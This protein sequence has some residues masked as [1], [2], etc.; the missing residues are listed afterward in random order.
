M[1]L[2]IA[3]IPWDDNGLNNRMFFGKDERD[4]CNVPFLRMKQEFERRGDSFDTI[5]LY[6][7][8]EEVDYF[9]FFEFD[10]NW[11]EKVVKAGG[12]KRMIYCNAEPPVVNPINSPQGYQTIFK[13]FPYVLTW[14]HEWID[15]KRI[16]RRNIPYCFNEDFGN[17]PFEERKLLTSISGNKSS[18]HPDELYSEREKVI[19]FFETHY[20]KDF[21]F[22]GTKWDKEKHPGYL[23][24]V[25]KKVETYHKYRFA[26]CFENMKNIS[27]YVT[28]KMLDCLTS[29]IV[30]VYAGA[31]NITDYV[32]KECFVDYFQ[33][34]NMQELADFLFSIDEETYYGYLK[35]A[36]EYIHS[37]NLKVFEGEEYARCIYDVLDKPN[38]F[39]MAL[40]VK[41]Y[42]WYYVRKC[43]LEKNIKG[44]IKK[45]IRYKAK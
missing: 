26:V 28:E 7:S 40:S 22:Y 25:E 2:K 38:D 30:P 21:D 35:A 24:R 44:A 6:D 41:M 27:D 36:K 1:A 18:N 20:P 5:D 33:F 37:G 17:I 4:G 9:L 8:L 13:Y 15:N 19:T 11:L 42:I 12:E 45:L 29:G 3:V 16:F 32:P 43:K 31:K 14:N 10:W 34:Q 23:G 39:K